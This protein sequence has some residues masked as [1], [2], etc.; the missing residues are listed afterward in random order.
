VHSFREQAWWNQSKDQKMAVH[1]ISV[2]KL[3]ATFVAK[4]SGKI[5]GP[6]QK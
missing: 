2:I 4:A 6:V 5:K 1:Y 3:L